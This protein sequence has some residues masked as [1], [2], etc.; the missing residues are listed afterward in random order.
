MDGL[1]WKTYGVK[2]MHQM[3]DWMDDLAQ[4]RILLG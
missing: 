2:L 4:E 3:D 1:R